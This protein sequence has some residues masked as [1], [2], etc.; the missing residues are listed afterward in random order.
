MHDLRPGA[1]D[2]FAANQLMHGRAGS[3]D[4]IEDHKVAITV[5]ATFETDNG[6]RMTGS[7]EINGR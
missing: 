2:V 4:R 5:T 7:L 1:F 6:E 3:I